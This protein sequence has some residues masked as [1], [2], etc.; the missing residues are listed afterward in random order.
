[1]SQRPA[2]A[3]LFPSPTLF[4]ARRAEFHRGDLLPGDAG[5]DAGA[6]V[7]V[8]AASRLLVRHAEPGRFAGRGA[9]RLPARPLRLRT[10]PPAAGQVGRAHVCTPVTWKTRMPS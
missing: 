3:A 9:G 5:G 7:P 10:G 4:R 1:R 8:A 6:N 2:S